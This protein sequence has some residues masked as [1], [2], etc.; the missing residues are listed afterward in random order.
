MK[1]ERETAG[2]AW[3]P[4]PP[5]GLDQTAD[6]RAPWGGQRITYEQDLSHLSA[7]V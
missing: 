3:K 5:T 4:H 1:S 6:R 7:G 2:T